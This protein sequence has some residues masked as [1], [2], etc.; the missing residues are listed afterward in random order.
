MD[1][2]RRNTVLL[3]AGIAVVVV[4]AL[5]LIGY[6]YY[7][8]KVVPNQEVVLRLG[9]DNW[10]F[11]ELKRR[12]TAE[13][14]DNQIDISKDTAVP[15]V[16]ADIEREGVLRATAARSGFPITENDVMSQ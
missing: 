12:V 3:V 6:G 11:S 2:E 5:A 7:K 8:D 13:S 15:N 1:P 14:R 9:K 10:D 16:L 4:F